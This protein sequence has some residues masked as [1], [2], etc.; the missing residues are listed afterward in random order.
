MTLHKTAAREFASILARN[1]IIWF[2]IISLILKAGSGRHDS[3]SLRICLC[4][5]Q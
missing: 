2:I 3:N 4:F 5:T 1:S